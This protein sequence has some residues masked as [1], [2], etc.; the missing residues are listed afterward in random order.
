MGLGKNPQDR[1]NLECYSE[2]VVGKVSNVF[3][4][5]RDTEEDP[6][7]GRNAE[8]HT[9][10]EKTVGGKENDFIPPRWERK[11]L[12]KGKASKDRPSIKVPLGRGKVTI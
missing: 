8:H 10:S 7:S 3:L 6:L 4:D 1:E 12:L 11:G 5:Q 2:G 9:R